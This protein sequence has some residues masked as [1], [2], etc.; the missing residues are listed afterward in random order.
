MRLLL[1]K[2]E[3]GALSMTTRLRSAS[4]SKG[5]P[6]N[7]CS[8]FRSV[9]METACEVDG[10]YLT[11]SS[12]VHFKSYKFLFLMYCKVLWMFTEQRLLAELL[13]IQY[14]NIVGV[15]RQSF[16]LEVNAMDFGFE[17]IDTPRTDRWV[18]F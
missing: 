12:L 15:S 4:T 6:V 8:G 7:Y 1:F 13:C 14:P 9:G 16:R 17:L 11:L 18:N 10:S 2:G 5:L 3:E